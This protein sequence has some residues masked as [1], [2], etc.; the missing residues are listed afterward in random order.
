MIPEYFKIDNVY[1]LCHVDSNLFGK[2]LSKG[3]A[4]IPIYVDDSIIIGNDVNEIW[5]ICGYFL[6]NL[7]QSWET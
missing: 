1:K 7:R 5:S 2:D 3:P 4:V 6:F